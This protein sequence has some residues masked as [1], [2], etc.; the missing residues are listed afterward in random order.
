MN[1]N[2]KQLKEILKVLENEGILKDIILIG[3][4]CPLFYKAIFD[5]FDA[6]VRTTDV[7][8]FVPNSKAIVQKGNVIKSLENINYEIS[9]DFLTHKTTFVSLRGFEIEFLTKLNRNYLTCVRLGNTEIYAESISNLDIFIGNYVE[10]NY[11]GINVKVASP[12]SYV[13]QKLLI[14]S[15]REGKAE[16]DIQSA[17]AVLGYITASK[18]YLD[19]LHSLLASLPKKWQKQIKESAE[20]HDIELFI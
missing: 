12:V 6:L 5:N 18:K 20:K 7:D 9:H 4:W 3:S 10:V 11:Y 2:E 13:L 17:K 1:D 19:E 14:S 15:K 16:K 8:F